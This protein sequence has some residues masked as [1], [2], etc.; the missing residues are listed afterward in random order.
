MFFSGIMTGREDTGILEEEI[1]QLK[2]ELSHKHINE[3]PSYDG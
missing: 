2:D 1:K 3:E